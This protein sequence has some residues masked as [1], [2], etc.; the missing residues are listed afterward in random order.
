MND[1]DDDS[2]PTAFELLLWGP[3][4]HKL[5]AVLARGKLPAEVTVRSGPE[6]AVVR[7][8][9]SA[10]PEF[11]EQLFARIDRAHLEGGLDAGVVVDKPLT[12]KRLREE[13]ASALRVRNVA[14]PLTKRRPTVSVDGDV[15]WFFI[16]PF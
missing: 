3:H 15:D 10:P 16:D 5:L 14:L 13:W 2:K 11:V 12:G 8:G 7:L 4:H 6:G 1:D 9:F